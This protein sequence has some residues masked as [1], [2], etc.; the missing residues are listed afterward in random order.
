MAYDKT[1][2]LYDV[3]IIGSGPAG[4]TAAAYASR[5]NLKTLL[6]TGLIAGG[7]AGGPLMLTTLVEDDVTRVDFSGRPLTAYIG[8]GDYEEAYHGKAVIIATGASALWLGLD[9]EEQFRG[10]GVSSCATCDGAFFRNR[11][12]AVVGGGDTAMEEAPY[13]TQHA[14][15][16]TIIH[17]RDQLRASHIMQE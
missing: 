7:T 16:V 13:L 10:R 3:L 11:E 15:K 9:S 2:V 5:A 17:R 4:W 6:F 8:E 12:I 1:R 14:S